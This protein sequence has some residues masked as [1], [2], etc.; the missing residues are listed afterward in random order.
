MSPISRLYLHGL[1]HRHLQG[2]LGLLLRHQ[3]QGTL[4]FLWLTLRKPDGPGMQR[5]GYDT[6]DGFKYEILNSL[7]GKSFAMT[8]RTGAR[9][10]E[11]AAKGHWVCARNRFSGTHLERLL[12]L[13]IHLVLL[14]QCV[15]TRYGGQKNCHRYA[16]YIGDS[17]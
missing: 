13:A 14:G 16:R 11:G 4:E 6:S 7:E 1:P 10:A 2:I 12:P 8:R 15:L 9:L 3:S 17:N 5:E